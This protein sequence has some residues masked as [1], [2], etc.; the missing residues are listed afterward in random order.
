MSLSTLANTK[1]AFAAEPDY[2][3]I[4]ETVEFDVNFKS[5]GKIFSG[6]SVVVTETPGEEE[7]DDPTITKALTYGD[8]TIYDGSDDFPPEYA[9]VEFI[10]G[11]DIDDADLITFMTTYATRIDITES[12]RVQRKTLDG[13]SQE[14]DFGT[15]GMQFL[16]KNLSDGDIFV[17][18]ED[19][20]DDNETAS[21]LIP[22]ETAQ[23]IV[24]NTGF[25]KK[26]FSS[27]YVKGAGTGD[28]EVQ[29]IL[30]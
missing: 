24:T 10:D 16:V 19:L 11:D 22:K 25:P 3:S 17:N 1:W 4:T 23:V 9:A 21:A 13:T 30:W 2:T 6:L 18:F 5:N 8:T 29:M 20:T 14:Y 12:F 26:E 7:G 27:I 28:V 15:P